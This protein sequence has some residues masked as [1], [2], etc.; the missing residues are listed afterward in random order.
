MQRHSP[1][2]GL[3]SAIPAQE[4]E[5]VWVFVHL[6]YLVTF[7]SR[8]LVFIQWAVQDLTFSRGTRLITG[9]A[10][11]D[12]NFSQEVSRLHGNVASEAIASRGANV[13]NTIRVD[14]REG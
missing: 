12:F 10:P 4:G 7:Q 9:A 8:L 5:L 1:S 11:T 14:G 3:V 6:M 13:G 2:A